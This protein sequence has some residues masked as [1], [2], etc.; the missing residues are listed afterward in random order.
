[1]TLCPNPSVVPPSIETHF[2]VAHWGIQKRL[3]LG[4]DQLQGAQASWVLLVVE[5][6][7]DFSTSLK[8]LWH[9]TQ[10]VMLCWTGLEGQEEVETWASPMV[11]GLLP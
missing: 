9:P 1:M 8:D 4:R 11:M 7:L 5:G 2:H 10:G 3:L 6:Y